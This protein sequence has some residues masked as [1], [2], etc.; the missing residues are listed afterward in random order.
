MYAVSEDGSA[1]GCGGGRRV[2]WSFLGTRRAGTL[3]GSGPLEKG[4]GALG[5]VWVADWVGVC[6]VCDADGFVIGIC[7]A[8]TGWWVFIA[9]Y[10]T[11]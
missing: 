4:V 1:G 10:C 11:S 7:N 8:S 3:R 6:M 2:S 9:M 5:V